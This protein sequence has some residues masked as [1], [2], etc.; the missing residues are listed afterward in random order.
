MDGQPRKLDFLNGLT[1]VPTGSLAVAALP[2][3]EAVAFSLVVPT[4]N[5]AHNL[6]DLIRLLTPAIRSQ[7]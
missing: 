5:E 4:R 2:A 1:E 6:R 7:V 3:R